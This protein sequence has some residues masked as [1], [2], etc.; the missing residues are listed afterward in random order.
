MLNQRI[1]PESQPKLDPSLT[2]ALSSSLRDFLHQGGFIVCFAFELELN[3]A[4]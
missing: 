1:F 2:T 4:L 3:E